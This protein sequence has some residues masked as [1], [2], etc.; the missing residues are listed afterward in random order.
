MSPARTPGVSTKR[1][2]F[3]KP[4]TESEHKPVCPHPYLAAH[5]ALFSTFG[6]QWPPRSKFDNWPACFEIYKKAA[7][8]MPDKLMELQSP[9]KFR[10]W[11]M[12]QL[13][14]VCCD[15]FF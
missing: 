3:S 8:E 5:D 2:F 12:E 6:G 11:L 9:A 7:L 14:E 15:C 1:V 4:E 13:E 10:E